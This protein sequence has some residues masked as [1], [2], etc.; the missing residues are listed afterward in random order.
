MVDKIIL[1]VGI[2]FADRLKTAIVSPPTIYGPGRGPGKTRGAQAY[3][4]AK[5]IL[6]TKQGLL[7]G[8][9]TNVWTQVHVWDLSELYLILGNEAARG[10]GKASWGKN[11][12]YFAESGLFVWGD[13]S[14]ALTKA[15][16]EKKLIPSPILKSVTRTL[17]ADRKALAP[18]PEIQAVSEKEEESIL[19]FLH[20][21]VGSNSRCKAIRAKKLLGWNPKEELLVDEAPAIIDYEARTLGLG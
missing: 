14:K 18:H 20:Y 8:K 6:Q 21:M 9:G 12:Y 3:N 10:G 16:F 13:V 7:I 4:L 11:T 1:E 5:A 19:Q 17:D 2:K 15:A